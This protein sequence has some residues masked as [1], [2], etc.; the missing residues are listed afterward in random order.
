MSLLTEYSLT[1]DVF[2]QSC[3]LS[4]EVADIHLQ[5]LKEVLLQE[6]LVRD[7][8]NGDWLSCFS[9]NSRSWHT[10]GKE[11]LK[12]LVTQK[13]LNH[14]APALGTEPRRDEEWCREAVASNAISP[15]NGIV[16]TSAIAEH[17]R[18]EP[19]VAPINRLTS[20]QWWLGRSP[21]V[22]LARNITAYLDNLKLILQC[23][24]SIMFI[25]PH[26]DPTKRGYRDFIRIILSVTGRSPAPI[27]EIHRACYT[28]SGPSRQIIDNNEW[29]RRFRQSFA[30]ALRIPRLSVNV[31]IWDDLHDRYLISNLLGIQMGNGFDVSTSP[32]PTTW[33]R[34]GRAERDD[35]QR[36]F[37]PVSQRHTL[38][39]H[40]RVT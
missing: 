20:A 7:L 10:R 27:L 32:V 26:L 18:G 17:F 8:R 39:H 36:E 15:L 13:R 34:L 33:S 2:D 14:C 16:T 3:Y 11:L 30:A 22:R 23:A 35:I 5:H 1:P 12:K 37:D 38:R 6:G 24:N 21:S 9:N 29:E 25:D 19:L 31:F 4:G 40:F 28:G